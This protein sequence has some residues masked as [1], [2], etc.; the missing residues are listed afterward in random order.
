MPHHNP[1]LRYETVPG[2]K[3]GT[4]GLADECS[5]LFKMMMKQTTGSINIVIVYRT[6]TSLKNVTSNIFVQAHLA[7]NRWFGHFKSH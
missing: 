1:Q 3:P 2:I 6:N 4:F 5:A 7:S